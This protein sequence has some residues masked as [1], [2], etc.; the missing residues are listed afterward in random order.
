MKLFAI[1]IEIPKKIK[2]LRYDDNS[3]DAN[4]KY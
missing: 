1:E 3:D 2:N 4:P